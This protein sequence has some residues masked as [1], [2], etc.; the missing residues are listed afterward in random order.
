MRGGRNTPEYIKRGN[1]NSPAD[2]KRAGMYATGLH[3]TILG[4]YGYNRMSGIKSIR[5][6]SIIIIIY[7][8]S[9]SF[10]SG[11]LTKE[12]LSAIIAHWPYKQV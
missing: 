6:V 4:R 7:S 8:F 12:A 3:N 1:W 2:A 5:R 10:A 11:L 9:F